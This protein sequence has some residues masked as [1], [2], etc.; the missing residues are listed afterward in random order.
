MILII[1]SCL[2]EPP[3]E[4][5]CFRDVTLFAKLFVFEDV[6]VECQ[7]GTRAI[8][9]NWLKSNGAHDFVSQMILETENQSGHK[10]KT[11]R[12]ANYTTDRINYS[13]MNEILTWI[14]SLR[15]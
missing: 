2:T 13:N 5:T 10:I 1:E 11:T 4:V 15:Y 14:R 12:G 8:Y 9:W 3:S 6:L 7:P